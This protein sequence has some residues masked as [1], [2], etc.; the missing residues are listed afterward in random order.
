MITA[1]AAAA[2]AAR[3]GRDRPGQVRCGFFFGPSEKFGED[4]P[5][6]GAGVVVVVR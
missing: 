4:G 1:K 3:G 6:V 2:A 5:G